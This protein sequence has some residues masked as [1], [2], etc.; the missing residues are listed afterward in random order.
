MSEGGDFVLL[1]FDKE[2]M[3]SILQRAGSQERTVV[4]FVTSENEDGN[5]VIEHVKEITEHVAE[6]E[7]E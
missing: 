2:T 7:N 3:L 4:E 1:G 5:R 6:L